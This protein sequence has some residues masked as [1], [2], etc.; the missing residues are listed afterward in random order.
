MKTYFTKQDIPHII[1]S[2]QQNLTTS[3]AQKEDI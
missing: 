1:W 2:I 3:I